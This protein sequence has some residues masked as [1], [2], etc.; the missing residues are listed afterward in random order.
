MTGGF[1]RWGRSRYHIGSPGP[2]GRLWDHAGVRINCWHE[3]GR[4][5]AKKDVVRLR[6]VPAAR[7]KELRA[8][9]AA[10]RSGD[11]EGVLFELERGYSDRG[12]ALARVA[13][14]LG[15]VALMGSAVAAFVLPGAAA[16]IFGFGIVP[17]A[18]VIGLT[19]W[20]S[21]THDTGVR[22]E[23][24]GVLRAEGWGGIT[25]LD[26]RSYARVTVADDPGNDIMWIEP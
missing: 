14:G 10:A 26:L 4:K 20:F 19:A 12:R 9:I 25:E 17:A 21:V 6:Q 13:V 23:G 11:A 8:A 24:R 3:V 18:M 7:Q 5:N 1:T 2:L 16:P 15:V 22:V